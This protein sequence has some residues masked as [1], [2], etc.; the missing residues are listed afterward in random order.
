ME[1]QGEVKEIIYQNEMNSYTVASFETKEESKLLFLHPVSKT[2]FALMLSWNTTG[3]M[4]LG[5][6]LWKAKPNC[7]SISNAYVGHLFCFLAFAADWGIII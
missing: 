6:S 7:I 4:I 2:R 5:A 1:I 3:I